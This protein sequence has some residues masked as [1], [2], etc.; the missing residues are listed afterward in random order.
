MCGYD[1]CTPLCA[2]SA[3]EPDADLNRLLAHF[4]RRGGGGATAD[5][6]GEFRSQRRVLYASC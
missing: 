3:V 2:P 1:T 5:V 4:V 6:P